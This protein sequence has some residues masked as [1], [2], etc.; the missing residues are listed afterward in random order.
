MNLSIQKRKQNEG[1]KISLKYNRR[2]NKI[3]IATTDKNKIG[4]KRQK[5]CHIRYTNQITY[6]CW[7]FLQRLKSI[8]LELISKEESLEQEAE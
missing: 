5:I 2:N 3:P 7:D 1:L 8:L 6:L 4:N